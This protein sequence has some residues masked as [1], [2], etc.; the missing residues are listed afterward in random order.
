MCPRRL[1]GLNG[2]EMQNR[3]WD[4]PTRTV[5]KWIIPIYMACLALL[6]QM[7]AEYERLEGRA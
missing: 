4:K 6:K 1:I 3:C 2:S 5:V 7:N